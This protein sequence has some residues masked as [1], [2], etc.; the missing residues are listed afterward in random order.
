MCEKINKSLEGVL[1][2]YSYYKIRAFEEKAL[3]LTHGRCEYETFVNKTSNQERGEK[4]TTFQKS[5]L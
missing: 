5:A 2:K 1:V 3:R 4:I